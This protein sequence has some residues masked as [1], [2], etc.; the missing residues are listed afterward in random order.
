MSM[1]FF[2]SCTIQQF[3]MR[4]RNSIRLRKTVKESLIGSAVKF[5]RPQLHPDEILR[6][7][8]INSKLL[9]FIFFSSFN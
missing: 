9:L 2:S 7:G 6:V 8:E 4:T 5:E 3:K 1:F